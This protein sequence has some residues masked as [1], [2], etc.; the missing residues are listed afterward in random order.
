MKQGWD[1]IQVSLGSY[2]TMPDDAKKALE[3]GCTQ[4]AE[5]L[6]AG[7]GPLCGW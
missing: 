1:A 5:A 3:D 2:A 4:G 6:K 7:V